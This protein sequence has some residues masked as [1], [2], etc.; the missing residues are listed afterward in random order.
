MIDLLAFSDLRR[1]TEKASSRSEPDS[2]KFSFEIDWQMEILKPFSRSF[3]GML[4]AVGKK[5]I[6]RL[7][8]CCFEQFSSCFASHLPFCVYF[9]EQYRQLNTTLASDVASSA[10]SPVLV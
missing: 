10:F 1:G 3:G 5:A 8:G 9:F 2:F 7:F 6:V 4:R